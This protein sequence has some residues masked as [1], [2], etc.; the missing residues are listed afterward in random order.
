MKVMYK[1]C[2]IEVTKDKCLGGWKMIF[3]SVLIMDLK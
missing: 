1:G 2:E 3:Y